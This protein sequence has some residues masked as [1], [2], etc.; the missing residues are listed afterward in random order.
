MLP[1]VRGSIRS[2][3]VAI[4]PGVL[5]FFLMPVWEGF[6]IIGLSYTAVGLF[7]A[8]YS[9]EDERRKIKRGE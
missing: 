1:E 9:Y 3:L 7:Y 5:G 4:A 6:T 2:L 8:V